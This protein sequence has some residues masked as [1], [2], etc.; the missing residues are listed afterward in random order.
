MS[1]N[2]ITTEMS[3]KSAAHDDAMAFVRL[4]QGKQGIVHHANSLKDRFAS[5]IAEYENKTARAFQTAKEFRDRM[6]IDL[7]ALSITLT[8][9]VNADT[10]REKAARLRGAIEV[11]EAAIE[12]LAKGEFELNKSWNF[13]DVFKSDFPTRHYVER[14]RDLERQLKELNPKNQSTEENL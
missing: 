11:I 5:V 2:L 7:R 10:H 9:T 14:I 6:M 1:E 12:R 13:E 8:M 3:V 4:L